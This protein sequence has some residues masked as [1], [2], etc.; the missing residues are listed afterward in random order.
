MFVLLR[1]DPDHAGEWIAFRGFSH[2]VKGEV[3]M[4]G[5]SIRDKVPVLLRLL[6]HWVSQPVFILQATD[7][8]KKIG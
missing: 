5:S 2:Q 4:K 3:S 7:L 1:K 6:V 8:N